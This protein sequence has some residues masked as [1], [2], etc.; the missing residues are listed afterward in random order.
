MKAYFIAGTDT[1]IGKT[2]AACALLTRAKQ[3]G[4][5]TLGLKPI[6][7]GCE[8]TAEGWRNSDALA[9]QGCSTLKISYQEVNPIVLPEPLSPHLAAK[10][11]G[12]RLTINQVSGYVR[13]AMSHRPQLLLVEGAGGWRVPIS[14]RELLSAL[15]KTLTLP[16]VLVVGL[17]LG[18]LNHA[19]LTAE[20][21]AKDGLRLAGWI[22]NHI[23]PDMLALDD[24]IATL[25]QWLAAPCL[26]ILPYQETPNYEQLAEYV[27]LS[28]LLA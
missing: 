24:N 2:T 5:S 8:Q 14:D 1:G 10:A 7:A 3:Q 27:D 16:V 25:K 9:L 17:R 23:Q 28:A 15:P 4:L 13:A 6:A 18:C 20:A 22:G 11:A 26:G 12:K 21:I 19:F